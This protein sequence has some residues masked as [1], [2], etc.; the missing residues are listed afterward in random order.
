MNQRKGRG[1]ALGWWDVPVLAVEVVLSAELT[2]LKFITFLLSR[3]A[4]VTGSPGA[5]LLSSYLLCYAIVVHVQGLHVGCVRMGLL[6]VR[7][8]RLVLVWR[9]VGA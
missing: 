7:W 3:T 2:R 1:N 9:S 5:H 4:V 6:L 8:W